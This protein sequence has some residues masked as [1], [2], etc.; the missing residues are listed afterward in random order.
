MLPESLQ[1]ILKAQ[2]WKANPMSDCRDIGC[3]LHDF[4]NYERYLRACGHDTRELAASVARTR[5]AIQDLKLVNEWMHERFI[6]NPFPFMTED[7]AKPT[8]VEPE[9]CPQ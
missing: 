6:E 5:A 4:D 9:G 1:E 8:G 3:A 2:C 7:E